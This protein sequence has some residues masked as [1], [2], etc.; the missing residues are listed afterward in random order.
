[1][2]FGQ[3]QIVLRLTPQASTLGLTVAAVGAQLRAA[4][5]GR[6][7]QIF[8][9]EGR[10]DRGSRG[11]SR[12]TSGTTRRAWTTSHRRIARADGAMPLLTVGRHRDPAWLRPPAPRRGTSSR[13]RSPPMWTPTV[14]NSNDG[15]RGPE[16]RD[17]AGARASVY[18]SELDA[19]EGRARA[20]QAETLGR[21]APRRPR[22]RA[23]HDLPS[24]R[25]GIR[26]L[27]MAAG[28]DVGLSRSAWWALFGDTG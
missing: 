22:T 8:Q 24:A 15:G 9:H 1:M 26:L 25:M 18:G 17:A 6:I 5:D 14:N 4:Y 10:G 19:F 23:R 16:A 28:G 27:R 21:H 3:E 2:P 7:A 12:P 13:S 11:A 20:D